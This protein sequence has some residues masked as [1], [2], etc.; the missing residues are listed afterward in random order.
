MQLVTSLALYSHTTLTPPQFTPV[1]PSQVPVHP[2]SPQSAP[3][4]PSSVPVH[5][6]PPQFSPSPPQSTPVHSQSTPSPPQHSL[7]SIH[8]A[9]TF[10]KLGQF[11]MT[12]HHGKEKEM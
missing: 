9:T 11:L 5:P 4:H 2:S 10:C 3:V 1:H 8:T 6:S 12:S 7:S